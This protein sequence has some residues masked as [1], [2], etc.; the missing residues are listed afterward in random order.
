MMHFTAVQHILQKWWFIFASC[1]RHV[2]IPEGKP[3]SSAMDG[4]FP[5]DFEV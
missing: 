4:N 5:H 2:V 1:Q 3:E